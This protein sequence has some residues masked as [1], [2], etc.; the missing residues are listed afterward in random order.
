[1]ARET[2]A[3]V[4]LAIT[5]LAVGAVVV[6]SVR[7]RRYERR[8]ERGHRNLKKVWKPFWMN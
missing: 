2:A 8:R 7:Y 5:I 6:A 1:M 4:I 3:Y